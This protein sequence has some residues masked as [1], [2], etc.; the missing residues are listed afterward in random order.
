MRKKDSFQNTAAH[1]TMHL[2]NH[3]RTVMELYREIRVVFMSA[4]TTFI[5]QLMDQGV[6]LTFKSYY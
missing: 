5:L 6:I 2:T 4:N 1:L 3:P